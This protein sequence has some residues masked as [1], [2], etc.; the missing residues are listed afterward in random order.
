MSKCF[1][2]FGFSCSHF[3][4]FYPPLS[5]P[6]SLALS[7]FIILISIVFPSSNTFPSFAYSLLLPF[8]IFFCSLPFFAVR[9]HVLFHP[10]L[11]LLSSTSRLNIPDLFSFPFPLF[12]PF[13]FRFF[14]Y[15]SLFSTTST[16]FFP[17]FL[18]LSR[19][20]PILY[21]SSTSSLQASFSNYFSY[22]YPLLLSLPFLSFSS[23]ALSFSPLFFSSPSRFSFCSP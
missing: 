2:S 1:F 15:L 9:L 20:R 19:P 13:L 14:F 21:P 3:S 17:L 23:T 18:T 5:F 22:S 7:L 6:L 16:N 12:Y 8:F 11:P 4:L 10:Y